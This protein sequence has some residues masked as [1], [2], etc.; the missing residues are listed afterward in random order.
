[1]K[2]ALLIGINYYSLPDIKLNGCINDIINMRNM[3]ID[4]YDYSN[5]NIIMLRD[6]VSNSSTQP[7]KANIM[8]ALN[9]LI[10]Q[11]SSLEELWIHYSGHGSQ[12]PDFN[13]DEAI[14]YDSI[15]VP[16]DY[17]TKG[18]IVDDDLLSI[19]KNSKCR[20]I[21]LSDSCHSGTVF[22]LPYSYEFQ[23]GNT[24]SRT[25]NNN[26]IIKN[27]NIFMFSGSKDSQTSS[28]TY[29]AETS[30]SVGAFTDAFIICL[31]N[32][33]HNTDFMSLYR[34][35]CTYLIN[36]GYE[37]KPIF[38]SSSPLPTTNITRA[39]PGKLKRLPTIKPVTNAIN[40]KTGKIM[41]NNMFSV[42]GM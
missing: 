40:N 9:S 5:N 36:K 4:A 10:A 25:L 6:D 23:S 35:I 17:R 42:M 3:L 16:I 14:G 21:I 7:T 39:M 33:Q 38:S 8:N 18:F 15:L 27:S 31:R 28:D 2:K 32:K 20:T 22:D 12:L 41:I 29:N 37:Q 1:M 30:Q 24:F 34:D 19:I 13:K 26:T 11:S